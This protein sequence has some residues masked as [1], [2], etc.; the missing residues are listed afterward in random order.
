MGASVRATTRA[1]R[2]QNIT[3][4]ATALGLDVVMHACVHYQQCTPAAESATFATSE[5]YCHQSEA[6]GLLGILGIGILY[7]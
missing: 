6:L 7:H 5:F 4:S 3:G 2:G 1:Y